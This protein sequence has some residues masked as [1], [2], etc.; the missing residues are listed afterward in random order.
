MKGL[1]RM[2]FRIA[3]SMAVADG[4]LSA[5]EQEVLNLL[6]QAYGID[7]AEK[8][9]LVAQSSRIDLDALRVV[10]PLKEDRL[11]ILEAAC[12]V[13]MADGLA[14]PEEWKL[15]VD[16]CMALDIDRQEAQACVRR[17]RKRLIELAR[18]HGLEETLREN[19]R[20]AGIL[21]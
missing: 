17:A 6:A 18:S 5:S 8:A 14:R 9:R 12:L 16:L 15:S 3:Y 1:Q 4:N 10:L 11:A 13:A 20:K 7:E 21:P 19:L 2:Q